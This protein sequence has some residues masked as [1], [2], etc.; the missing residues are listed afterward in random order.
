MIRGAL[1]RVT[2]GTDLLPSEADRVM[3]DIIEGA[4]TP[5]QVGALLAGLRVKKESFGEILSF[6]GVLRELSVPLMVADPNR[7]VDTCGTGGDGAGTFNISTASAI[8]AAGAGIP[9]VKHGNRGVSSRCGSSDVMAALGV[10]VNITPEK[11]SQVLEKAGM[12]F[13]FA[14]LYHPSLARVSGIRGELGIKTVFNLLGPLANPA[15]AKNQVL[16]VFD[17]ALTNTLARVLRCLGVGRAMVVHGNG[18]DEIT[19]TGPTMVAELAGGEIREYSISPDDFGI[20]CAE[21]GQLRGGTATENA[22]IIRGI[23]AGDRGP[24]R[25]VVLMNAGAAIYL[26]GG[27]ASLGEGIH[28]AAHSIDTHNAMRVLETLVIETGGAS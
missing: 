11:A 24:A 2:E 26:G 17:P 28:A 22:A 9:V 8:V 6:A 5:A 27:A 23:L 19:T 1:A 7:I 12:V 21:P 13:L 16:G 25:D 3:R 18:M 4:A 20:P 15:G 14:P 10:T